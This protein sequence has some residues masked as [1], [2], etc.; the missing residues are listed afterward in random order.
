MPGKSIVYS[1]DVVVS[2][3]NE[4]GERNKL[5]RAFDVVVALWRDFGGNLQ[6]LIRLVGLGWVALCWARLN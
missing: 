6:N 4:Q 3:T 2:C 1:V 5:A